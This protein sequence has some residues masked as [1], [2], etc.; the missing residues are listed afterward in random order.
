M[1]ATKVWTDD[2]LMQLPEDGH[3]Y[4]LVNGALVVSPAGARHG[5][6]I[7]R[8][9]LKLGAFVVARGLGEVFDSS[10]GFRLPGGNLRVPDLSFVAS[11]RLPGGRAPVGFLYVPPDLAVEVLSPD[12]RPRLVADKVA[13]YLAVGVRLVWVIDPETG[14]ATVHRAD[15]MAREI[16]SSG[17]LG[18]DD[19]LPGFECPLA[20]LFS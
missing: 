12:D 9:T 15:R 3:K 13:E 6:T 2:E 5:R 4:E 16:P 1:G 18:G 10:T 14:S 17:N 20:D 11:A 8:L 19:V 7:V